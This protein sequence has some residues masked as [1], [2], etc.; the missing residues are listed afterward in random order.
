MLG[1]LLTNVIH[2]ISRQLNKFQYKT[3][4]SNVAAL[5]LCVLFAVLHVADTDIG[6]E[7]L[8]RQP[9]AVDIPGSCGYVMCMTDG[10]MR[11]YANQSYLDN[12]SPLNY[13]YP[14]LIQFLADQNLLFCLIADGPL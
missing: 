7:G 9:F 3:W 11:V 2:V 6:S 13:P 10:I 12:D 4:C 1:G 5:P 8:N 14:D